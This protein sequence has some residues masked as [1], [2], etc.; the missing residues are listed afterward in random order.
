MSCL[1]SQSQ[2][3]GEDRPGSAQSLQCGG[4]SRWAR[5]GRAP[6]SDSSPLWVLCKV[7]SLQDLLGGGS[8]YDLRLTDGDP[9]AWAS[10]RKH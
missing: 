5:K 9:D 10:E 7:H 6:H 8:G 2:G 3:E 1:K 4:R